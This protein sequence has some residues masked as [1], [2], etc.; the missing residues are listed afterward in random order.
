MK[1]HQA[2]DENLEDDSSLGDEFIEYN[3]DL[4]GGHLE[5]NNDSNINQGILI[6]EI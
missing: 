1:T 5:V 3:P 6:H 2:D 4:V